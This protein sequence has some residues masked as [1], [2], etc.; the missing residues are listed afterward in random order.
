MIK[1]LDPL[2]AN[3]IAAGE[4]VER[5]AAVVKELVENAIDAGARQI[6]VEIK[7]AGKHYIRVT[8]N[9]SGIDMSEVAL[10]FERHA[11]S[12]IQTV[13]DIYAIGTLGFRGEALASIAS[14]SRMELTT[15][16]KE[17]Q[18]GY[19]VTVN[20]GILS[21][22]Q[23]VGTTD[24]TTMIVRDLFYNTP[25]RYQFLKSNQAEQS[26][27]V[28]LVNKLAV[29][30]TEIK[31]SLTIDNK[32]LY[33]TSGNHDLL[34]ALHH[35]YGKEMTSHMVPVEGQRGP[36][37]IRGLI[38]KPTYTRGNKAYQMVFVNGRYV[39]SIDI[40]AAVNK[41]YRGLVMVGRFPVF[42]LSLTTPL[43]AVDVNIHPAK[44]EVRFKDLAVMDGLV[45]HAVKTALDQT[46]LVPKTNLP[47]PVPAKDQ[48]TLEKEIPD[49]PVVTGIKEREQTPHHSVYIPSVAPDESLY[50]N[51]LLADQVDKLSERLD[52]DLFE[53]LDD[54][55]IKSTS[56]DAYITD[57]FTK[58]EKV[59]QL[60][61]PIHKEALKPYDDLII[62][63]T[64]F[65]SY[66]LCQRD[67]SA[68]LIDQHAA[69]ERVLFEAFEKASHAGKVETQ[70]LLLPI[71]YEGDWIQKE[72]QEAAFQW[73][74]TLG[75]SLESFGENAWVI[76]SVPVIHG[77]PLTEDAIRGM[78]DVFH[79]LKGASIKEHVREAVIKRAC[80]SAV[81]AKDMLTPVEIKHL[82]ETLNDLDNPYTCPHGR[83]IM[84]ELTRQEI[85]K[86]F[87]RI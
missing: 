55:T 12:K 84:V 1:R 65:Q 71:I 15:K 34:Y 61:V 32:T 40:Q 19:R 2:V 52:Q 64:L 77:Q 68:F 9:G 3:K 17:A 80:K 54:E 33:Q 41:A 86:R 7:E 23:P 38:A 46:N 53:A 74:E 66:I 63:G 73:F 39:K 58:D 4:V 87:K 50:E 78:V 20:G 10:A 30:H 70:I 72:D 21:H 8:D 75:V 82:F 13:E 24:G 57:Y 45:L 48:R 67:Q 22:Q 25:A 76:R 35:V 56:I 36:Y 31:F 29:S 69:H 26:A 14:V 44:T 27:I 51:V 18:S 47:S 6:E 49:Q 60:T 81:K 11:T 5:P 79:D 85:E 62:V 16:T 43:D 37:T 42:A 83:P 28:D 59:E